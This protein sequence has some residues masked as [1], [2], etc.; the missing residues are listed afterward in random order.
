MNNFEEE[1]KNIL[2]CD[3][4]FR[5]SI[6]STIDDEVIKYSVSKKDE[7][8]RDFVKHL[9]SNEGDSFF[10]RYSTYLKATHLFYLKIME[11]KINPFFRPFDFEEYIIRLR[12]LDQNWERI[13]AKSDWLYG[14]ITN[15]KLSV[16]DIEDLIHLYKLIYEDVCYVYLKPI[17]QNLIR[18]KQVILT[19]NLKRYNNG[20][21]LKKISNAHILEVLALFDNGRWSKYMFCPMHNYLRNPEG[22]TS[23]DI[24]RKN[25]SINFINNKKTNTVNFAN[26]AYTCRDMFFLYSSMGLIA[27]QIQSIMYK[28]KS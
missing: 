28:T 19:N 26:F 14:L 18:N 7:I 3:N 23:Y 10:E 16:K 11:S 25:F 8:Y 9:D 6:L 4:E 20:S 2:T 1:L 15:R 22:H 27:G 12:N 13:V 24:D 17:S 5:K 21:D